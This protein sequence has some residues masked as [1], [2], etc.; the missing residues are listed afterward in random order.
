[1]VSVK[2]SGPWGE[3]SGY[4]QA[5]RNIIQSLYDV[6]VDVVTELQSYANHP[7]DYGRQFELAKSLQ[8]KHSNYPIKVLHI[9][10][11]VY[12]KN[13]E[14]FKYNIGHLFW[15]TTKMSKRWQW[16]LNE[17]RE[18]WTGCEENV[19]TFRDS[20]FEGKIFKFPQ[21]L[22][23]NRTAERIPIDRASGFIFGSI[24][25]WIERKDP[26]S[27]LTAYWQEF[28]NDQ[29][30]TLVIKTYG[31]GYEK[32]EADQ[33][34]NSIEKWKKELK[35]VNYPRTLIIDYLLS[36]NEIHQ[37][38]ESVDCIVT[39]HRFE[40]WGVVQAESLVHAKPLIS[41]PLGGVHEWISNKAYFP[42]KYSMVD[43]F[44]MDW[45]EQYSEPGNKWGQVDIGDLRSKMRFVYENR[46][47]AEK[48]GK[49]G[50]KEVQEKLNFKVVGEMM[51][52]RINE[53]YGELGV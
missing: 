48:V 2:Y 39:P 22:D 38:Y 28:E 42:L 14:P 19:K 53:I 1:M 50:Q 8:N 25:Q 29:N 23:V 11:N 46:A 10:P 21:P 7:T 24:F 4:A 47:E 51:K 45:A 26:K 17:V 5:N 27:L 32:H 43:V 30:V 33:I 34:Y 31:L 18:I 3:S 44:G 49:R 13:K 40:G 16:Y 37:L 12:Q 15:E 35:Q 6:G 52:N 41:T 20:G 9:T 36:D